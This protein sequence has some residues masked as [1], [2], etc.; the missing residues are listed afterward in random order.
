MKLQQATVATFDEHARADDAVR[1]LVASGT[2]P[3]RISIVGKGYHTEDK[4]TGFYNAGDRIKLWGRYGAAW[5]GLWGLLLGG[6]FMVVPVVGPVLI[7]GHLGIMALGAVEGAALVGGL[8]VIGG[9]LASLG[10]PKNSVLQ[11]EEAV[12]TGKF[13][14]VVHGTADE[15]ESAKRVLGAAKASQLDHYPGVADVEPVAHA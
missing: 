12:K 5:G 14:I 2:I 7:L 13:L 4:V 9:A 15:V 8:G 3:Q 11:Y 1:R 10:I 6:L